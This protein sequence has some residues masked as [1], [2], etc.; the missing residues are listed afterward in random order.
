MK[1]AA[2]KSRFLTVSAKLIFAALILAGSFLVTTRPVLAVDSKTAV[3]NGA[4]LVQSGSVG[5]STPTNSSS[6]DVATA[7]KLGLNIFSMI[8]G[9]IAVVMIMIGGLKYMTSQGDAN[10]VNSAKNT[11]LYAC[12][13]I[14]VVILSQ[15]II[16]FVISRFTG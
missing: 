13:G 14:V 9:I 8:I 15:V 4:G 2:H 6:G 12:V 5:C 10:Q 1:F 7:V 16:K 11:I 3:C